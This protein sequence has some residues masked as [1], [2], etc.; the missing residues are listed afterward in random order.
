MSRTRREFLKTTA[1]TAALTGLAAGFPSLLSLAKGHSPNDTLRIGLIGCGWMGSFDLTNCLKQP[2]VDLGGICDVDAG[3]LA[4]RGAEFEK[5]TGKKA[6]TYGDYRKLLDDKDLDLVVIGTP[7]HWHCLQTV[8]ALEAGK[9]VYVEKPMANSIA[10]CQ[11]MEAAAKRYGTV[12]QVGQQQ[13]SGENWQQAVALVQSGKLGNIRHIKIWA[14]F[15]YGKGTP[16]IPDSPAPAESDYEMWL[17]PAPKVPY[18]AN[19][20]HGVW[21]HHWHYG[22]GL[23][24]DWGVHLLDIPLWAMRV[25]GPPLSVM[26]TGGIFSFA[27]NQ[28]E[29]P[30][31]LNVLYEF[32]GFTLSWEHLGGVQKGYYGRPYGMAFMGDNAT[33]VI[34]RESWEVIPNEDE[35]ADLAH[36]PVATAESN[37]LAHAQNFIEA[38][39]NNR[40]PVCTVADGSL[41]AWYAHAGNIAYRTR[42]RLEWD[43]ASGTFKNNAAANALLKPAYRAPWKFPS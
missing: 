10:E 24:T 16:R 19:R 22:G 15:D 2:N 11:A 38:V 6:K 27:G 8:H 40:P 17:G 1:Q 37:H 21:R 41:A 20:V 30:D 23:L 7:D 18:N 33:L 43:A 13:R 35:H 31:T 12:V 36:A 26:A 39:R 5:L 29:T 28:L 4:S 14:N 42:T 3:R 32:P 34:N 25:Q 9:A